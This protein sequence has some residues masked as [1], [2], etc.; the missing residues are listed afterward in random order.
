MD[1]EMEI[2]MEQCLGGF[3]RQME[4]RINHKTCRTSDTAIRSQALAV[5]SLYVLPPSH[6]L[7][8]GKSAANRLNDP[9]K[10]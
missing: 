3:E 10:L 8:L 2:E 7:P 6:K 9:K 4:R 5:G 1:G